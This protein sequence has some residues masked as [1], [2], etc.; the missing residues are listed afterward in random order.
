VKLG[1]VVPRFARGIVGGA[2]QHVRELAL[3][4]MARGHDVE[5]L[6]SC[7]VDHGTWRNELRPGRSTLDGIPVRRYPV[8]VARDA[9]VMRRLQGALDAGLTLSPAAEWDWVRNTGYSQPLLGA[10]AE[11]AERLD[12]L[13]FMP[14]LFASTVFGARVRPDRSL[15]HPL[16]HDEAYARFQCVQD[17]LRGAAGILWNSRGEQRLGE[18]LLGATRR[19]W[20]VGAGVDLPA[21]SP[22]IDGLRRRLR[23]HHPVISYAG[24]R[25]GAKNFPLVGEIVAAANLGWGRR[26]ELLA[27][28]SGPVELPPSARPF[29][30]DLGRVSEA[31]KLAAFAASVAVFNLS[32]YESLSFAVLEAWSVSTPVVVHREC[33]VTR[34]HCEA[35][36]GGLWI[37]DTAEGVEAILRLADYPGLREA[38]G[39]AGRRFV[40][41]EMTW[42]AAIDR[43]EG[44]LR[45]FVASRDRPSSPSPAAV[46]SR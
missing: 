28:G 3:R 24:R 5:V 7:A 1:F 26:V 11:A 27:M 8:T 31:V 4:L 46:P 34:G 35:S 2:E 20:W 38:L 41:R 13:I 10:I 43:V 12:A 9:L 18:R 36:G 32:L 21:Q 40:E 19:S 29:V 39:A 15:I 45:Q 17:T 14:Y 22:D 37:G 33:E 42:T 44:A 25:E 16:L 30:R 23:L 6:T